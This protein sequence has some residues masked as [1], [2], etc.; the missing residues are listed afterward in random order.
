[1]TIYACFAPNW[2]VKGPIFEDFGWLKSR[3]PWKMNSHYEMRGHGSP[4]R[5][6]DVECN[7]F[8]MATKV[9]ELWAPRIIVR[10]TSSNN[11]KGRLLN[12]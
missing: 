4:R 6:N 8:Y 10:P 5:F 9:L 1:M 3:I 11:S 2:E 12:V 7:S